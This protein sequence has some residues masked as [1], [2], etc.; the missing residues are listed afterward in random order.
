MTR[1][2]ETMSLDLFKQLFDKVNRETSQYDAMTFPGMGEPLLDETLDEKIAYAKK[3]RKNISI[4]LLTNGSRLTP[5]RFKKLE[6]LGL[7]SIRVSFYGTEPKGYAR[8]HGVKQEGLFSKISE[9]LMKI[10]EIKTTTKLLLT[11]NVI[12]GSNEHS[13]DD[14]ID[15]WEDKADLVEVWRPHNWVDAKQYRQLQD[16]K[17]ASCGRPF[18]GPLQVQVD[19]TI[20]MCCFDFNG[21]LTLGDFK[22]QTLKDIFSSAFYSR[23][24]K[25]HKKGDFRG[26]GLICEHC[27]QRNKDKNNVMLYNS[28]FSIHERVKMISTTYKKIN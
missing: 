9:N 13:V 17:V 4:L 22:T 5:D 11:F 6:D 26:T 23:I 1:K 20:N 25:A 15:L 8:V 2:I 18:K 16:E 24:V 21:K 10:A 19:G 28:R 7:T 27:D 12:E 3:R 14:W